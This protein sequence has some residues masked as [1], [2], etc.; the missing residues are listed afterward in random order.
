MMV[1]PTLLSHPNDHNNN[2]IMTFHKGSHQGLF[3]DS[4]QMSLLTH[5]FVGL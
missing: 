5:L 3:L 1:T 2:D 4:L